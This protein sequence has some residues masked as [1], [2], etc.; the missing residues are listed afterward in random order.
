[1]SKIFDALK[2]AALARA[3]HADSA[4]VGRRA[5]ERPERRRTARLNVQVPLFIYGHT[6]EGNPFYEDACTIE[7]NAH[8]GLISMPN[9]V[10]PGQRLLVTKSGDEQTQTCVVLC[11]RARL[12]QSFDV[13]FEFPTPM[14]H[15]WGNWEAKAESLRLS[16]SPA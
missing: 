3:D 13:A 15:F 1:M 4:T 8:G 12:G 16:R 7:I 5:A 9:I 10:R 2:Q 11:V 6:P 14:L